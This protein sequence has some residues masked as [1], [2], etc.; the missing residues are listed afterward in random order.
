ME[1]SSVSRE[2]ASRLSISLRISCFMSGKITAIFIFSLAKD[3]TR[4][5]ASPPFGTPV[6]DLVCPSLPAEQLLKSLVLVGQKSWS[7]VGFR[8]I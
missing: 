4:G 5:Q 7:L 6:R 2:R 3:M 8:W 1:T